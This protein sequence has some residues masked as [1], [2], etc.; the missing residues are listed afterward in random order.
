[1]GSLGRKIE[2]PGAGA[3]DKQFFNHSAFYKYLDLYVKAIHC[4]SMPGVA[5]KFKNVDLVIIRGGLEGEYSNIEHEVYPG[6]YESIKVVTRKE[7]IRVAEYA[8]EHALLTGRK[9]VSCIHKANMMKLTDGQ[10]LESV[11]EVSKRYPNIQYGEMTVDRTALQLVTN[12]H[13]FD[14]MVMPNLY[15]S[16]IS[17]IGAGI[18]GGPGVVAGANFGPEFMLFE[19]GTR[20]SGAEIAG[21][22]IVNPTA[23]I[24]SSANMLRCLGLPRFGDLI[25]EALLNV[26]YEGRVLTEDVGG[27]ATTKQ[28]TDRVIREIQ[29]LDSTGF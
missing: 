23:M 5:Q 11:R 15:G 7:A 10:F 16:I 19:Q 4:H 14:V 8:F 12:P 6:V 18:A 28:F 2:Q 25:N 26:Y 29:T 27:R 21:Q 9:K 13:Q 3:S 17:A 22:G 20:N 1:M 24:M